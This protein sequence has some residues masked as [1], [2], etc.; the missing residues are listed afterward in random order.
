MRAS[1]VPT[2]VSNASSSAASARTKS[3]NSMGMHPAEVASSPLR[4]RSVAL[5]QYSIQ[6]PEYGTS[7]RLS[8]NSS[9]SLVSRRRRLLIGARPR[10]ELPATFFANYRRARDPRFYIHRQLASHPI[11]YLDDMLD[12]LWPR[13]IFQSLAASVEDSSSAIH[14]CSEECLQMM[15]DSGCLR[16]PRRL[17][18]RIGSQPLYHF[19]L[20]AREASLWHPTCP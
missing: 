16:I 10:P 3:T 11:G 13:P 18:V 2:F 9:S 5:R 6:V 14:R 19:A 20:F 15:L 7:P 1:G 17:P 4:I 12:V 8:V